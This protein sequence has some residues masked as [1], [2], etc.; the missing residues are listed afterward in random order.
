M[1]SQQEDLKDCILSRLKNLE[2]KVEDSILQQRQQRQQQ[3]QTQSTKKQKIRTPSE[4]SMRIKQL[5]AHNQSLAF[6]AIAGWNA[7]HNRQIR[8][9]IMDQLRLKFDDKYS[10]N[11]YQCK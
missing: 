4:L 5:C 3:C 1:S 9:K 2:K 6:D 7:E 8:E 10:E 11:E